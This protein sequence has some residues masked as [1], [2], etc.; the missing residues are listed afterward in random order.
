MES[1]IKGFT[2]IE[3]LVVMAIIAILASLLLPALARAKA[4]ARRTSCLNNLRQIGIA[5]RLWGDDNYQKYPWQVDPNVGGTMTVTS[6]WSH[7]QVISHYLVTPKILHCPSDDKRAVAANFSTNAS[8]AF[9][10]FGNGALSY[11]IGT[12]STPLDPRSN[13]ACDRNVLG[14]TNR[15]CTMTQIAG[16][17]WLAPEVASWDNAIHGVYGN[18]L[19]GDGSAPQ[20]TITQLR[21]QMRSSDDPNFNNCVLPP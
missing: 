1:R 14:Y 13:V 10:T 2:L 16:V 8:T 11:C 20:L 18:M 15:F 4:K 17:M 6:A 21:S 3:L 7:A 9:S 19:L 5:Y 12:D